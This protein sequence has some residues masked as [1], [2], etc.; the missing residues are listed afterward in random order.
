MGEPLYKNKA[1]GYKTLLIV[2]AVVF[3]FPFAV[4]AVAVISNEINYNSLKN[5]IARVSSKSGVKPKSIECRDVEL[6]SVC[7]ADYGS[8]SDE[9]ATQMLINNGYIFDQSGERATNA[10]SKTSVGLYIGDQYDEPMIIRF[11]DINV[12]L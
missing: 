2:I 1:A 4:I 5:E 7:Y 12:T 11:K 8:L 10:N 6:A 3:S 9:D